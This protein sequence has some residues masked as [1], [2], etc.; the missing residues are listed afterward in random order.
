[1]SNTIKFSSDRKPLMVAHRGLSALEKENTHAAFI[2]A[3][4]RSYWG[5]ETDIHHTAD[6]KYVC[7]H[8]ASTA[9]VGIDDINVELCT[10]D[11][12]RSLLLCE[13]SGEKGR[14]D[15]RIPSLEEYVRICKHYDKVCVLELKGVFEKEHLQDVL[16]ILAKEEW[17][18]HTVIIAFGLENLIRLRE[19]APDQTAQYLTSGKNFAEDPT[20][21]DRMYEILNTYNLDLDIYHKALTPEMSARVHADGHVVNVWTVDTTEDAS[22]AVAC[23]IEYMTSNILE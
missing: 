1:M 22:A 13:K 3:G 15:I 8:D 12:V 21:I 2:A 10:Y 23:G 18:D 6:G 14:T 4:N 20:A 19:I 16:D 5:I 11:T 17:Q 7:I 9:R